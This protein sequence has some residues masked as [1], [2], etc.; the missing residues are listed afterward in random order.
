MCCTP[1]SMWK[2]DLISKWISDK[3]CGEISKSKKLTISF[4]FFEIWSHFRLQV[5]AERLVEHF[6]SAGLMVREWDRVKLHGTVINTLFRRDATGRNITYTWRANAKQHLCLSL[7]WKQTRQPAVI[8][9]EPP[10]LNPFANVPSLCFG[11]DW[12]CSDDKA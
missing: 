8:P 9:L 7:V 3:P 1:K 12:I 6:V 5:I 10:A 4:P 11:S 2:T